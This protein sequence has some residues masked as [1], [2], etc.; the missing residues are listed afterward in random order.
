MEGG[1]EALEDFARE[2]VALYG[3]DAPKMLLHRAEIADEHGEELSA[4][5][6]REVAAIAAR[7]TRLTDDRAEPSPVRPQPSPAPR[8][9]SERSHVPRKKRSGRR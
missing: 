8:R 3:R 6:W 9:I 5:T 2:A 1:K 4:K 7:I